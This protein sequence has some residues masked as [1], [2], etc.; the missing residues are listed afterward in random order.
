M[1][2][3]QNENAQRVL[4]GSAACPIAAGFTSGGGDPAKCFVPESI[5]RLSISTEPPLAQLEDRHNISTQIAELS[6][7]LARPER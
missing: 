5:A 1:D 4:P 7:H 6:D 3:A 2:R